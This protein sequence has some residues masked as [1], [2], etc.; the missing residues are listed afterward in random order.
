MTQILHVHTQLFHIPLA[1]ALSDAMHGDHPHFE[2]VTTTITLS[3]GQQG[4]GYT[5]TGG[6]GGKGG[7]AIVAMVHHD[8][9]PLLIG[10]DATTG[11]QVGR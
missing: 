9:A 6:K 11:G 5:C 2:L 8:L 10:Q 3:N 1:E 4:T 7:H